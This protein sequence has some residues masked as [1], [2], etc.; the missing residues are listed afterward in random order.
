[1]TGPGLLAL[2]VLGVIALLV[3]FEE[4]ADRAERGDRPGRTEEPRKP[5]QPNRSP[6]GQAGGPHRQPE[7]RAPGIPANARRTTV[8]DVADGDTVHLA[9]LGSSRLIGIDTPEVYGDEEC[10]GPEASDFT[11]HRLAP[12]TSVYFTW[13]AERRDRY[14]RAL[15]YVWLPDG[16]FFN[17]LLA[18]RGFAVPLTIAPNDRFAALF[19]RF[20]DAAR[21]ASRG[22]WSPDTCGGDPELAR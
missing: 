7:V 16:T 1:M 4:D 14:E 2:L 22:L 13:G 19:G 12:G 20:A 5:D 10:F 8:T 9:G 3:P 17:G 18:K 15:V 21:E 6:D 11:K